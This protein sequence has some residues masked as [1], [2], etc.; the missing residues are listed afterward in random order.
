MF[1]RLTTKKYEVSVSC[2]LERLFFNKN[3]RLTRLDFES[4]FDIFKMPKN[5]CYGP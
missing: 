5:L 4:K 2:S 1:M 3:R